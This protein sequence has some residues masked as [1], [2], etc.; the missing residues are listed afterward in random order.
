MKKKQA[1]ISR[2]TK[3]T[4]IIVKINLE[5]KGIHEIETGIPFFNHMLS[6]FSQHSLFDLKILAKG[7]LEVDEHHTIEDV[8]ICLGGAIK[9][10]L[11]DKKGIKRFG[12]SILPMEEAL[13]IV[14]LDICNRPFFMIKPSLK[15]VK[16]KKQIKSFTPSLI[17]HFFRSLVVNSGVTLHINILNGDNFHHL[18]E[19]IFKAMALA[20]QEAVEINKRIKNIPSSKGKL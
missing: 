7:D 2:K 6:L 15:K 10:A 9:K 8:G 11:K 3:E 14:G 5:G 19:A 16:E 4:D 1:L 20:F 17:E 13:V 12:K 18:V